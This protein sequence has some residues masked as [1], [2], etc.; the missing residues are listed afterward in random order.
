MYNCTCR[1]CDTVYTGGW[2][3]W[4]VEA[5]IWHVSA[6][7]RTTCRVDDGPSNVQL[8]GVICNVTKKL[9]PLYG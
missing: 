8:E 6:M 9:K 2:G 3:E 1:V 5:G 7:D 4:W